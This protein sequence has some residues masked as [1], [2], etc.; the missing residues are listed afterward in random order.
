MKQNLLDEFSDKIN[1]IQSHQL[2]ESRRMKPHET[3]QEYFLAMRDSAHRGCL[4]TSSLIEH[5]ING[6]PDS[7]Q[8]NP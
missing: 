4:D 6:F 5:T 2:M 7:L 3:L 8:I 1:S